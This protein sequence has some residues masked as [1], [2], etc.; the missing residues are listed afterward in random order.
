MGVDVSHLNLFIE[1]DSERSITRAAKKNGI[2]QSAASQHVH[3]LERSLEVTLLDRSTRP[4]NLT[5]AGRLYLD[6]CRDAVR[7]RKEFESALDQVK[8]RVEETVRVACIY[9]IGLAETAS[10]E[11]GLH[12][13][14]PETELSMQFL[15]PDRV[16]ESVESGAA[17]LGIVSYPEATRMLTV[18]PW[19]KEVM[20]VA[21]RPD[22]P[23]V[24]NTF[25]S[26]EQLRGQDFVAFDEDLPIARELELYLKRHKVELQPVLRFDNVLMIKEAVAMGSGISILPER[27]LSVEIAQERLVGIPLESP[28]LYRPLGVIHL[29][30][31]SFSPAAEA[32]LRLLEHPP[33]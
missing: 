31:K 20:L 29:R 14:F 6:Y 19:R 18:I 24:V 7:R 33:V 16:Y 3:E 8:E 17:D 15:R 26:P 10:W 21:V 13:H 28:G 30:R 22:H 25:L 11:A 27:S 32:F 23:L 1:I 4:L 9:S 2:S 12:R 5:K